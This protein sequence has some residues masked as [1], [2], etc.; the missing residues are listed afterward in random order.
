MFAEARERLRTVRD[1]LRFGVSRFNA[2]KLA[3]GHGNDNALDEAAYLILHTLHLPMDRLEGFLDA[4]LTAGEVEQVLDVLRQRIERRVPAAYLTNEAWLGDHRF[5]VDERVIVPRSHIAELLRERLSPWVANPD[6]VTRALDLCTG[7]GCL[8]IMLAHAFPGAQVDAVDLSADA[9][10]VAQRNVRDYGLEGQ[11]TPHLSDLFQAVENQRYQVIVSN[12]PYVDAEAM[13]ALPA[14][15]LAEPRM[16]LAAGDD[17]LDLVR[18]ILAQAPR[19]LTPDGVLIVEVGRDRPALEA[20]YPS[21]PFTW[22][23]TAAGEDFVFCLTAEELAG[24]A[25]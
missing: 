12:P 21:L 10:D 3:F 6:A 13:A 16:A 2:E 7:S 14:E 17:G 9:L 15:Y 18:R 24:A 19:H 5:Y 20:A 22:I 1:L 8:A 23:A 4:A 11:V 25:R